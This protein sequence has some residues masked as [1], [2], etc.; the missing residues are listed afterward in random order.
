[1]NIDLKS[2]YHMHT[3][4]SDGAA[5]VDEMVS[6]AIDKGLRAI[7]ITDH[8]PLPFDNRY[9]MRA[10]EIEGYRRQIRLAKKK[11]A[12]Q[13]IIKMGLEFEYAQQFEQWTRSIADMEWDHLIA[14]VHSLF[15][16][17]RPYMTNGTEDEFNTLVERF[18]HNIE[19]VCRCYYGAMQMAAQTGLFDIVGHLDVIKKH[20]VA[21]RYFSE[22]SPWYRALVLET[23]DII[24]H[25]NMK[26]EINM[27]GF[28]HPIG[29]QYPSKW[30]LQEAVERDVR[31][32]L[33][34]DSH[35]PESLGQYFNMAAI[36][37]LW[38]TPTSSDLRSKVK[39]LKAS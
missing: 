21:E 1:M 23:L 30:I 36:L 3:V 7:T 32:V 6:A 25:R 29:E 27:G 2:D 5:Q 16:D 38:D 13:I 17:H 34:S 33:S 8:M 31:L 24:K 4:F 28:N 35:K 26:M 39:V 9:A 20:N 18:D 11:Y 14:S 12:G 37:G 15:I 22:N 19:E 10:E